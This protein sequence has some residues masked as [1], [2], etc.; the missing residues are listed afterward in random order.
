MNIND[1]L[2][3]IISM[4]MVIYYTLILVLRSW[5]LLVATL[6]MGWLL[7]VVFSVLGIMFTCLI[8]MIVLMIMRMIVLHIPIFGLLISLA[9]I[10]PIVF[11]GGGFIVFLVLFC[12]TLFIY[13]KFAEFLDQIISY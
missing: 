10:I 11:F 7:S 6:V 8:T 9:M 13:A 4:F 3:K 12:I 2:G 5:K 1:F